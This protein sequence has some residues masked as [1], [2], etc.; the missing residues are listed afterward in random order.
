MADK[1][2]VIVIGAGPGGYVAAI[3]AA[4]LGLKTAC[5]EKWIG[6]EGKVVHGGTCLNVGCI[7]SKALLEASHKYVEAKHDF[8][9]MGIQAGDVSMDVSKMMARKDKIVKQLTGGISG[10]FKA[11]GVT[12]IEG[13]GKVVA[14]NKVE[15][16]DKD[17]GTSTVEADN[18]VIA[19]G[20]VPVE[21][22][23]TPLTEGLIVDSTGA[24]EFQDV[25]K[26]LGVIGA[27]VIGLELGSVWSRLGSDVTVLEALDSFLPMVDSA[28]GKETQKL[29][30]KQ[31]LDIKLNARVTGSE[32]KGEEVVVKYEDN[33]G[34][35]ELTFDKLIVCVGRRPYTKGV[36]ADGLGVELDQRGFIHVDDQCRTSVPG[37]FAIGDCVR[38]PMLAHKASEEG[39]MVADVI[40]GHKAQ[41]NYDA[42][43]SVIYTHPEVAWVGM[44]EQDAKAA[45]IKVKTGSF[46][47]AASGRAMANNATDG[48]AKIIADAETD[49]V[50]GM[51][52][53]GQ[54][55]GELIAQGVIAMEFGSSAEDL[56][57]TCYA[58]PSLSEAVHEAALAVEG[59]AIHVAN[60]K[61][62]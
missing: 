4:Q 38:G 45:G 12:A 46:P 3:R 53:V 44:N 17:G 42:I 55:A 23:P 31:G 35:K 7:P 13:T 39:V 1:Y 30:K 43:P 20:S 9:D 47:F 15:V 19:A 24:L 49:R 34:E 56:A 41:M 14:K 37:V 27:G 36:V 29:L 22:P 26:R 59:H 8:D 62:R 5:V 28:I 48:Q 33:E 40:A 52:I 54:H 16:T 11:N 61:K 57:L 10:L 18:I 21:I 32:V 6:K 60:R 2:D 51:H 25:P 58:H 50:L